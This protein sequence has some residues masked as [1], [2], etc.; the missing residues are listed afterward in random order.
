M[1]DDAAAA[2]P[3]SARKPQN[4]VLSAILIVL[5]IA[6]AWQGFTL[7]GEGRG[8]AVPYFLII[9]GPGLAIFYTWYFTIRDFEADSER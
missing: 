6:L 7:A 4:Y 9:L 1:S 8:G 2:R 3:W 5:G